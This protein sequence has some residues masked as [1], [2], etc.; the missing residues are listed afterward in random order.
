MLS[1]IYWMLSFSKDCQAGLEDNAVNCR[2]ITKCCYV[3]VEQFSG[4]G[5]GWWVW[6]GVLALFCAEQKL[7]GGWYRR[8]IYRNL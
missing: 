8:L 6:V 2:S 5:G 3:T 4:G 7:V 1:V